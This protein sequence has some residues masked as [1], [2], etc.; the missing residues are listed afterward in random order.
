MS[1]CKYYSYCPRG[2]YKTCSDND[3]IDQCNYII[4]FEPPEKEDRSLMDKPTAWNE[5]KDV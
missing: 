2:E 4:K 1:I 3:F 5:G